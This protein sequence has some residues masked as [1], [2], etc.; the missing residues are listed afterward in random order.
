MQTF[1]Y[2]QEA[3][4][5]LWGW[6]L[7]SWGGIGR[8]NACVGQYLVANSPFLVLLEVRYDLKD[9]AIPFI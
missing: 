4:Q 6:Q 7:G 5:D 2:V 3:S 9:T 1:L 8:A